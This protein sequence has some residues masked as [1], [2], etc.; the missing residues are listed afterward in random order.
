MTKITMVEMVYVRPLMISMQYFHKAAVK[1]DLLKQKQ[2]P[3]KAPNYHQKDKNIKIKALPTKQ[4]TL[5][6]QDI[7]HA[8]NQN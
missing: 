5:M 1:A 4:A 7:E 6:A 3:N 2:K 8:I